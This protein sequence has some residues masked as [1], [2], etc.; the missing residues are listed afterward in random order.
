MW[1]ITGSLTH[2]CW[3][4][5][6]EY[7]KQCA[8]SATVQ[9]GSI[10]FDVGANVGFYTLLSSVL[11]GPQGRVIAFEPSQRNVE[12]LKRHVSMNRISNVTIIQAGVAA[13]AG[14]ARFDGSRGFSQGRLSDV[15]DL[16]VPTVALDELVFNG[17]VPKPGIIKIDVEGGEMGVLRG[18]KGLLTG[19]GPVVFLA[20]HSDQLRRACHQFLVSIGYSI[21]SL[22]RDPLD[23]S[24]EVVANRIPSRASSISGPF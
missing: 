3:L 9:S 14:E 10:V 1:W 22:N 4:G 7:D 12:Y 8:F 15:G 18:A 20:T 17:A 19:V 5:S 21:R 6:Y 24:D 2:G 11:V 23:Q 13:R 16:T